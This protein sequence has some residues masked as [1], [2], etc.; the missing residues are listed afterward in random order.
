[1][2]LFNKRVRQNRAMLFPEDPNVTLDQLRGLVGHLPAEGW[3]ASTVDDGK[4]RVDNR[5]G[6]TV[7]LTIDTFQV[8][9]DDGSEVDAPG[10]LA[11]GPDSDMADF[12]AACAK[13]AGRHAA[14]TAF[15][16]MLLE[17]TRSGG[18]ALLHEGRLTHTG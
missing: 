10:I 12:V 4:W 13:A 5:R 9:L 1:M 18:W 6:T 15:E 8:G 11:E 3:T 14:I 7:L 2:G 16:M 17:Q